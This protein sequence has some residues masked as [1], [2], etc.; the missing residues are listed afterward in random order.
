MTTKD[1]DV[2][3]GEMVFGFDRATDERSLNLFMQRLS[4]P[5]LAEIFIPRLDDIEI[6]SII[7]LFSGL[8]KKHMTKDEYH[9]LF[10]GEDHK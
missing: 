4:D 10:L 2:H 7:D 9:R 8:M 6:N 3:S 1:Q 5:E